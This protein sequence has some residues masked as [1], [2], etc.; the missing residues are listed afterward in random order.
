MFLRTWIYDDL[1]SN[2]YI[3]PAYQQTIDAF[4]RAGSDPAI[5]RAILGVKPEN[6][7]ASFDEMRTR[8]GTIEDYFSKVLEIDATGQK[9]LHELYLGSLKL[10]TQLV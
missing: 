2:D 6:L 3:L 4:T 9:A 8:Y 10:P 5:T 1:R 7:R